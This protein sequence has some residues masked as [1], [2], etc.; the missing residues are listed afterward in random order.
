[1]TTSTTPSTVS[2]SYTGVTGLTFTATTDQPL[3]GTGL[4]LEI[5]EVSHQVTIQYLAYCSSGT[6]C[7]SAPVIPSTSQATYVATLGSISNSYPPGGLV[8]TS[9]SVT[10]PPWAIS[11]T[12]GGSTLTATTNYD[13]SYGNWWIEVFDLTATSTITYLGYCH[14]GTTCTVGV[15]ASGHQFIA[16]A[17]SIS[18]SFAPSPLL[19]VSNTVGTAGPTGAFETAGGSN[20]AE[21]NACFTCAGDPFNTA[22]GEFFVNETDLKVAGR[23]PGL[24]LTR[25]YSTQLS[26]YDGPLGPGWSFTYGMALSQDAT[27]GAVTVHQENGSVVTFTPNGSGDYTAPTRVLAM[28]VHNTDGSWTYTRRAR[29]IFGFDPAGRL[30]TVADLNGETVSVAHTTGGQITTVTDGPGRALA[31]TYNPNGRIATITDPAGRVVTYG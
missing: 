31:F 14:S 4:W 21:L 8:A 1:M 2:L 29:Q 24:D 22:T 17:G 23:G 11:L 27:T 16:T 3:D 28:V 19:A 7:T 5:F 18:N 30:S 15:G 9:N 12:A 26:P 10:P 6:T 25:S 20:Q 13:L